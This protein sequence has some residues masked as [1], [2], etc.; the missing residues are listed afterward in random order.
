MPGSCQLGKFFEPNP[1]LNISPNLEEW[2]VDL[3]DSNL[4]AFKFDALNKD[5]IAVCP[6]TSAESAV[7]H[8]A[9]T[10]EYAAS[11][12]DE[13]V[14]QLHQKHHGM[15]AHPGAAEDPQSDAEGQEPEAHDHSRLVGGR[16]LAALS[17][18]LHVQVRGCVGGVG[19]PVLRSVSE[20]E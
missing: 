1:Y 14:P 10:S 9:R 18:P 3:I 6:L 15:G 5:G 13:W 17:A 11:R 4:E 12:H 20:Y 19:G 7:F 16:Q 2:Q 8:I